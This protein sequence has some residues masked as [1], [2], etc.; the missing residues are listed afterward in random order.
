MVHD[1]FLN[2]IKASR[3]LLSLV[4]RQ[5]P[6]EITLLFVVR[7]DVNSNHIHNLK[8]FENIFQKGAMI[9]FDKMLYR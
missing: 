9:I 8:D 4:A 2:G 1:L 6:C 5:V 3:P 7:I